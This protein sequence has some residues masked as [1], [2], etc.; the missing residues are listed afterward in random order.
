VYGPDIIVRS[1][2]HARIADKYGNKWQYLSRSDNHSKVACWA[3]AFD[4]M[5]ESAV[6]RAQVAAGKVILG[7]NHKM[8]NFQ[9][10]SDKRLDLV[11]ARPADPLAPLTNSLNDLAKRWNVRLSAQEEKDLAALPLAFQSEVG[12]VL[13]ATEAKA[14]MTAHTR[15]LPRL[16]DELNSSHLIVHGASSQA[17]AVGFAMI[18]TS[19]RFLSADRNR[20]DLGTHAV[21]WSEEPQPL[22][23]E[24]VLATAANLP[25]RSGHSQVGFDAVGALMVDMRNDGGPVAI[26]AV[27]VVPPPYDYAS[28]INRLVHEYESAF[29]H[30]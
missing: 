18:G 17:L 14:C 23:A 3:I 12:S 7:V 10:A 21:T 24:R 30:I 9:T 6:L 15:A 19:P 28:M 11:I 5:R 13:V 26:P 8:I 25:R 1:I 20:V 22:S 16:Y 27:P 29:R 2:E 4:F